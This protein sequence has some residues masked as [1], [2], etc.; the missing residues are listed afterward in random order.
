MS[1]HLSMKSLF[2]RRASAA[3]I[4]VFATSEGT[5]VVRMSILAPGVRPRLTHCVFETN[6]DG[7][8]KRRLPQRLSGRKASTVSVLEPG[9]YQ[10]LLVEAPN[11]PD[12]ELRA[13]VRWRI[14]DLIDYPIDDAVIEVFAMPAQARGGP[15]RMI[16]VAATKAKLVRE[17][18]ELMESAGFRLGAIDILELS[19][20]NVATLFEQGAGGTALLYVGEHGSILLLMRQGV[21]YV[22][23]RIDTGTRTLANASELRA[24]LGAR[25]ALEVRRSLDYFESHYEQNAI[26]VL[27]SCGLERGDQES[28]AR[29]LSVAVRTVDLSKVLDTEVELSPALAYRCLPAIGA[30]L[31]REPV[32]L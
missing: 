25:L 2:A 14:K 29:D 10:L 13:A 24:E 21:L 7:D 19:L 32:A 26:E 31:R 20:R 30:A 15:N 9:A 4:G 11:V 8:P 6:D 17:Q 23:R 27:Y 18:V 1:F 16:T 12:E 5:A 28:L 3:Q 22:T